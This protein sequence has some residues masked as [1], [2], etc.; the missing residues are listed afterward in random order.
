MHSLAEDHR[1]VFM[2]PRE[3]DFGSEIDR[4]VSVLRL[5]GTGV[6]SKN[7]RERFEE[8][9][10]RIAIMCHGDNPLY[11]SLTK[12]EIE[13]LEKGKLADRVRERLITFF[14]SG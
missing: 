6:M 7:A 2:H 13:D 10:S 8:F 11:L 1:L 5:M 9:F 14:Q 4:H 3:D 12:E